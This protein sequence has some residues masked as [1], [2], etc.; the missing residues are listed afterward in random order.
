[1]SYFLLCQARQRRVLGAK[2]GKGP[3]IVRR[4]KGHFVLARDSHLPCFS[5]IFTSFTS[6]QIRYVTVRYL[7]T[8][9]R[10]T[11]VSVHVNSFKGYIVSGTWLKERRIFTQNVFLV[12][13]RTLLEV[14][15][16]F[17]QFHCLS[18]YRN[19]FVSKRPVSPTHKARCLLAKSKTFPFGEAGLKRT[20]NIKKKF[21]VG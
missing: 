2:R 21:L 6:C 14:I 3:E 9:V 11:V 17:V 1:M 7:H 16:I 19:D 20:R 13:L 8:F 12:Q 4:I 10:L 5:S 15:E 18:L